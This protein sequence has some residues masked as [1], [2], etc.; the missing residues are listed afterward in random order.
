MVD[1]HTQASCMD[2]HKLHIW[3]DKGRSTCLQCHD[4]KRN[5]KAKEGGCAQC[6]DF[7]AKEVSLPAA[8]NRTS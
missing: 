2:C 5:H 8:E 6:H 4:D 3:V 1:E 7:R